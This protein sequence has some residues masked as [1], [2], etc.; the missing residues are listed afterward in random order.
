[1]YVCVVRVAVMDLAAEKGEEKER[2]WLHISLY[3]QKLVS[4]CPWGRACTR[5]FVYAS[6]TEWNVE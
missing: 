3:A 6:V 2:D 5:Y 1:M 4:V